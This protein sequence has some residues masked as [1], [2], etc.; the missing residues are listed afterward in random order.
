MSA[1]FLEFHKLKGPI[2]EI[3]ELYICNKATLIGKKNSFFQIEN[4]QI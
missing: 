3:I 2:F 4:G 1:N